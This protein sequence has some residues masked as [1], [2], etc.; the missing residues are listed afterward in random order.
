MNEIHKV[1]N[2]NGVEVTTETE[3]TIKVTEVESQFRLH[4]EE[5]DP[6]DVDPI[7]AAKLGLPNWK[8]PSDHFMKGADLELN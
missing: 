6:K 3:V 4:L 2:G 5:F 8:Q 7:E 1:A